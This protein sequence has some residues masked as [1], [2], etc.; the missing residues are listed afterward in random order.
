MSNEQLD[1]AIAQVLNLDDYIN[2]IYS[3]GEETVFLY[4]G[5]YYTARKVGDVHS[6]LVCYPGQGW[7]LSNREVRTLTVNKQEIHLT[8]MT[9]SHNQGKYMVL[10]WYQSYDRTSSGTF[11]QKVKTL[12][13]KIH[14]SKQDNAFVRISIPLQERSSEEAFKTGVKFIDSFYPAFLEFITENQNI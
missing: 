6:P 3:N 7:Q 13:A 14:R 4:V 11:A 2:S 1:P 5:Y 9:A 10:Y 8:Q 12:L